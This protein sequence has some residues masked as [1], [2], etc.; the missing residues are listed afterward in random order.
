MGQV[1]RREEGYIPV[2][3]GLRLFYR[4]IGDGPQVVL[5]PSGS[6]L[7]GDVDPLVTPERTLI[8]YD[9]RGRGASDAVTDASQV[10]GNYD[11]EDLERVRQH[12]GIERMAIIGWSMNGTTAAHY[13]ASH[14]ERVTRLVMMCPGYMRS[15]APYFDA[16]AIADKGNA[17]MPSGGV[18]RLYEMKESELHITQPEQYCKEHQKVYLVRQMAHPDAL[19]RMRSNPCQYE[20]EWP[21][22][23]IALIQKHSPPGAYDWRAEAASIQASTLVIHGMEDLIPIESS[24]E[25]AESIPGARFVTIEG[26]GHYPHL[27]APEVF[28]E[29]VDRFLT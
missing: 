27:E 17:R 28:F 13:A 21:R 14:P 8:F 16:N 20:N 4:Q 26:S 19:A 2:G 24:Q 1:G 7:V 25:W 29:V 11:L 6:W 15:E 12:L 10:Q 22:N 23:L 18:E 5:I 9:T 3:A